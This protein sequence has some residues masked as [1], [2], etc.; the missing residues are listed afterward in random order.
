MTAAAGGEDERPVVSRRGSETPYSRSPELRISHKLAERKRRKEM[1][2]LFDDLRDLLPVDKNLKT[3]KWE[4]LSK[5][6]FFLAACGCDLQ[7]AD[8]LCAFELALEYIRI[9]HQRESIM[10]KE[11]ADLINELNALKR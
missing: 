11:K 2:D 3:S 9:L 10:E 1:K 7:M 6:K 4:I 8:S 5:S